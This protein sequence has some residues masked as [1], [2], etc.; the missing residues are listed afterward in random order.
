MSD[1][2]V[3]YFLK[4]DG[5]QG[6]S[7]HISHTNEIRVLNWSWGGYSESTV[8]RTQGSGAGKVTM[9]PITIVAEL[10]SAY[11]KLA[12]FLTQGKHISSGTLS[13]VKQGSN[14]Q[15]F[16]TIQLTEVFVASM[17]VTA[18]GQVPVVNLT[19]TYKSINTQYKMQNAQGNLTTAGTHTYDASTNQTS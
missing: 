19:L 2:G 3:D 9:E 15:D 1:Q 7:Q 5:A 13:A 18:S 17:N 11:T 10:D 12:G 6:E 4:L 14:N 8:G 16:I